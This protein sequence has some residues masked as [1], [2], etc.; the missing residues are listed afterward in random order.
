MKVKYLIALV[1]FWGNLAVI[2]LG[3]IS[4]R[5]SKQQSMS[6]GARALARLIN[7]LIGLIVAAILLFLY[8]AL[9]G[10]F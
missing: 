7:V 5:L 3:Q 2:L 4:K 1:L 8:F 10:G 9:T 6:R